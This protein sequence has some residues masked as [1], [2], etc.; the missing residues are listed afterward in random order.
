MCP[1]DVTG[2]GGYFFSAGCCFRKRKAA[3]RAALFL[4][5]LP[6]LFFSGGGVY[7]GVLRV[8]NNSGMEGAGVYSSLAAAVAAA[9]P[10]DTIHVE[11]SV[12]PYAGDVT[13]TKKLF[14]AGPGYFL[15]NSAETQYNKE[16]ARING[17]IT[18]EAG[19]EGTTLASVMHHA[20]ATGY[21][22]NTASYAGNR[23]IVKTG[24]ISLV[25]CRLFYVEVGAATPIAN[26]TVQRCFFNPGVITTATGAANIS[27][28]L[29]NNCLFRNDYSGYRV[30]YGA[31]GTQT[32][33][34]IS[35]CTF[36]QYFT[37][38]VENTAVVN[39]AFFAASAAAGTLTVSSTN[40]YSNNV[41]RYVLG[42]MANGVNS[43]T[44]PATTVTED[45]WFSRTGSDAAVD[46]F[47]TSATSTTDC[48]LRSSLNPGDDTQSKGMYGGGNP[49]VPAGL[50]AL[51]AVY[52]IRMDAEVG[53]QFNM[54]IKAKTHH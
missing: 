23:I 32:G 47:F 27:N 51:P 54:V 43:N 14:I 22:V 26:V 42:G 36:Y 34:R 7:G 11:G 52:D 2:Y 38:T 40:T 6:A 19:S 30:I 28:L 29:I 45:K 44:V 13:V 12:T 24:N 41:M 33:W 10:D 9:Q 53:D 31:T 35:Q 5:L 39:N 25:S 15:P 16:P 49:Y 17:N 3:G 18:F 8:N 21:Q 46:I 4:L 1:S 20:G 50:F 48:P 37:I